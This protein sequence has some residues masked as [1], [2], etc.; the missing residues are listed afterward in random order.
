[1]HHATR[2]IF[3]TVL[4]LAAFALASCSRDATSP[5]TKAPVSPQV[6]SPATTSG[7]ELQLY[8]PDSIYQN[9]TYR[10]TAQ[11]LLP[12][13]NFQWANRF[14]DVLDVDSCTSTWIQVFA[15]PDGDYSQHYD[16]YL[17]PDCSGDSTRSYQIRVIATAFGNGPQTK[18]KV[19]KLCV[20][21]PY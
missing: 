4:A 17:A 19:T 13:P 11:L 3:R 7:G 18:Y 6:A 15:T 5:P 1:M 14:C 2:G 16:H 10:Y 9:G 21:P 20:Q 8:G 12:Y